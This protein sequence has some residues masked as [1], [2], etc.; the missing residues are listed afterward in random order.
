[1]TLNEGNGW[2]ASLDGLYLNEA[3]QPIAY[4]WEEEEITDYRLSEQWVEGMVTVLLNTHTPATVDV[5]VSKV[6]DD[7]GNRDG[8]RP[9]DLRVTL[10]GGRSVTLNE[11]NGWKATLTGL[12]KYSG[13]EEIAYTWTEAGVRDYEL[14][15]SVTHGYETVLTNRHET[16]T[17]VATV[18]KVWEDD[19][20]R[21][22]LRPD[23]AVMIL[24]AGDRPYECDP[25]I[26]NAGNNW[27]ATV[28]G[29]PLNDGGQPVE[30]TWTEY[31]VPE[32]YTPSVKRDGT[33]TTVT[34][35]HEIETADLTVVKEWEDNNDQDGI[36]P[37]EVR[38]TLLADGEPVTEATLTK[39]GEWTA[40]ATG[41]P[42]N[43]GGR[44]IAYTWTEAIPEG[45]EA[46]VSVNALTG[47]TTITNTHT[48][49]TAP[50]I[51]IKSWDDDNDRDGVRPDSVEVTL[52]ADEEEKL[53]L[54]LTAKGG[55]TAVTDPLPVY[56]AGKRIEYAWEE[57]VDAYYE[58][59]GVRTEDG[60]TTLT[61][62]HESQTVIVS[63][64]KVWDDDGDRDRKRPI[65][66]TVRLYAD[67][68]EIRS[69]ALNESNGWSVSF[70]EYRFSVSTKVS[71]MMVRS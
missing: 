60:V 66:V 17:T 24:Y 51:V 37:Q 65:S 63:A 14:S 47:V 15:G 35:V 27:T 64:E 48:P 18:I 46:S 11:G 53:S 19:N 10:S 61:N 45:Y 56:A 40:K 22:G 69:A 54:T 29:L 21:D 38:V 50:L 58:L 16:D 26:L 55:W 7:D 43:A 70:E 32:G 59:A 33:A 28:S 8:I 20:D 42:V 4:E 36:R 1:M 23:S 30:Y 12:P 2:T 9:K 3:G 49:K 6:W 31:P 13:G 25:V 5:T 68:T 34:N 62:T 41:L 44:P 67:G 52:Y 71:A 57:D 39:A